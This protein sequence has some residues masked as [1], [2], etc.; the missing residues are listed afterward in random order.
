[1]VVSN[2]YERSQF[3]VPVTGW[4]RV[5]VE[6]SRSLVSAD[7]FSGFPRRY[8]VHRRDC[9]SVPSASGGAPCVAPIAL[10]S[11]SL[12]FTLDSLTTEPL[13]TFEG[14]L[15]EEIGTLLD[16]A[17]DTLTEAQNAAV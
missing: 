16:S 11:Y 7:K 14:Y 2:T 12:P 5:C 1:M 15:I 3:V 6:I 4:Y 9:Q 13:S 10:R 17:N 8:G